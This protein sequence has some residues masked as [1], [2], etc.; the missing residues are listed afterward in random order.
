MTRARTSVLIVDDEVLL[1]RLLCEEFSKHHEA[2]HV[3]SAEEALQLLA[4]G[5]ISVE[6]V[7]CDLKM[8]SMGGEEFYRA[9]E[10]QYPRLANRFV[11]MTGVGFAPELGQFLAQVKAPLLEKPFALEVALDL[12]AEVQQR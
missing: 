12:V 4:S 9:V 8:P 1:G 3:S 11:F 2:V 7:F 5:T 6:V 10:A